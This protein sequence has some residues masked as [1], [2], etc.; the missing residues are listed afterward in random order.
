MYFVSTIEYLEIEPFRSL[1]FQ[2]QCQ[3]PGLAVM[4]YGILAA[5]VEGKRDRR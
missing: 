5:V 4:N 1:F 2:F 3:F